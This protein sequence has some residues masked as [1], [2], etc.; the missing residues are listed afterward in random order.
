MYGEEDRGRRWLRGRGV[1]IGAAAPAARRLGGA[2]GAGSAR[3]FGRAARGEGRREGAAGACPRESRVHLPALVALRPRGAGIAAGEPALTL[4]RGTW[5]RGARGRDPHPP[6]GCEAA[7][8]RARRV[9]ASLRPIR[10]G[11]PRDPLRQ[12]NVHTPPHT[13]C[14]S[15]AR[16]LRASGCRGAALGLPSRCPPCGEPSSSLLPP[17]PGRSRGIESARACGS[18]K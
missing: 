16:G 9:R 17:G 12:S 10:A 6:R 14:P 18:S 4:A 1:A 15:G 3:G 13:P 2:W 8:R 5:D 11:A 7:A